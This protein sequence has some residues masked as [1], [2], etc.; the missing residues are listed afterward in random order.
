M[1]ALRF[2]VVWNNVDQDFYRVDD[3]GGSD[4]DDAVMAI[5]TFM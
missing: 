2:A 1:G 5:V 4:D 3:N